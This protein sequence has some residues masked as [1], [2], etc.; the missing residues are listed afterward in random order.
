MSSRVRGDSTCEGEIASHAATTLTI[1]TGSPVAVPF[2]FHPD[3][4]GFRP[5][6]DDALFEPGVF[7]GLFCRDT[8]LRVIDE[9]FLEQV[10]KLLVED[11]VWWDDLLYSCVSHG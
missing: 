1:S 3:S 10:Q 4:C 2:A 6:V 8:L 5:V 9:D 11:G 7:Q